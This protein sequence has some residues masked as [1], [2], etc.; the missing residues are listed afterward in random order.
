MPS[1][2]YRIL[3]ASS[4]RIYLKKNTIWELC[5]QLL[6]M[7]SIGSIAC[8]LHFESLIHYQNEVEFYHIATTTKEGATFSRDSIWW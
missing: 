2:L 1:R 4:R 8:S 5:V 3:Q 7:L 6:S